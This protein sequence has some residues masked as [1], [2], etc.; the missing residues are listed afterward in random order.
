VMTPDRQAHNG[1]T[2]HGRATN[3]VT[4]R[5]NL[6]TMGL[7][8]AAATTAALAGPAL[9][10]A[11]LIGVAGRPVGMTA[12][13]TTAMAIAGLGVLTAVYLVASRCIL[14]YRAFAAGPVI[15]AGALLALLPQLAVSA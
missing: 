12:V 1:R 13:I 3:H 11:L 14:T 15:L 10:A 7:T 4:L 9:P 8:F 6:M 2:H 5:G